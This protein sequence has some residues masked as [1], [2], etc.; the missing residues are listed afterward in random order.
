MTT[1]K[2]TILFQEPNFKIQGQ[3]CRSKLLLKGSPLYEH[4]EMQQNRL[5]TLHGE[6]VGEKRMDFHIELIG[7]GETVTEE[8]LVKRCQE[9]QGVEVDINDVI[10]SGRALIL[11]CPEVS[12]YGKTHITI[13]FFPNGVPN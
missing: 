4:L 12:G 1:Q 8:L 13:A 9:I 11:C 10:K 2:Y 6:D 3:E 7:K 5:I